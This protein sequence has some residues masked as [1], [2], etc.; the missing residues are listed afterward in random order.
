[1]GPSVFFLKLSK[2]F[3]LFPKKHSLTCNYEEMSHSWT[4]IQIWDV[5]WESRKAFRYQRL[6]DWSQDHPL[7]ILLASV[8]K[9]TNYFGRIK[10]F[11]IKVLY[12]HLSFY[13]SNLISI[14]PSIHAVWQGKCSELVSFLEQNEYHYNSESSYSS[15]FPERQR[16]PL[17]T[18]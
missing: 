10:W 11:S 17:F 2:N 4:N 3:L 15:S 5:F 1:M 9:I 6:W 7:G 13:L 16:L 18:T 8:Q 14:Y 12:K